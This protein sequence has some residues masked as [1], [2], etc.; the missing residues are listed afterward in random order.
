MSYVYVMQA[1]PYFKIGWS[2]SHPKRRLG[3]IRTACPEPAVLL[4]FIEGT[5]ADEDRLHEEYA[6]KNTHGEWFRLEAE[7]VARI[8]GGEVRPVEPIPPRK[9]LSYERGEGCPRPDGDPEA[10]RAIVPDC[11]A[12]WPGGTEA[13]LRRLTDALPSL[14]GSMWGERWESRHPCER[15]QDVDWLLQM[16]GIHRPEVPI[17]TG[18]FRCADYELIKFTDPST[19]DRLW[20]RLRPW[21]EGA[22]NGPAQAKEAIR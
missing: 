12:V 15:M 3:E 18:G 14:E 1:G 8:L 2:G 4:G 20:L 6:D 9:R 10:E 16:N 11:L 21:L 19:R 17:S 5:R 7:D 22:R 13:S